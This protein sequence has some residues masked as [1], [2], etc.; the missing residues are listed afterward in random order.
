[1][2]RNDLWEDFPTK[3]SIKGSRSKGRFLKR[4]QKNHLKS[5]YK[6]ASGYP[7]GAYPVDS[8]GRFDDENTV[9]YKRTY[10]GRR[11]KSIKKDCHRKFRRTNIISRSKGILKRTT[12]FWWEYI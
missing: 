5:L 4:K 9:Y 1:M 10:R 3:E 2:D 12:E 8:N 6:N 11:S 7:C